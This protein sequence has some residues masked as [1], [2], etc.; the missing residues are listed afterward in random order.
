ML[1]LGFPE[2]QL[3]SDRACGKETLLHTKLRVALLYSA[4]EEKE[5]AYQ[6]E[7]DGGATGATSEGA[8]VEGPEAGDTRFKTGV[9][10]LLQ[11]C[12]TRSLDRS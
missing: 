4:S 3:G 1:G 7:L 12:I 8:G 10:F 2:H 6:A 11:R 5:L 9:L